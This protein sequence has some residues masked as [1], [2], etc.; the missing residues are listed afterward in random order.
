MASVSSART[1]VRA[2]LVNPHSPSGTW[3]PFT[4]LAQ[5]PHPL[6]YE[7]VFLPTVFFIGFLEATPLTQPLLLL[8]PAAVYFLLVSFLSHSCQFLM[9]SVNRS[10]LS[11]GSDA[12]LWQNYYH[13]MWLSLF[14]HSLVQWLNCFCDEG[15]FKYKILKSK[16]LLIQLIK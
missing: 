11:Q 14:W 15:Y 7:W 1:S 8:Y 4:A 13:S 12:L 10:D 5:R 16:Y 3:K 9:S 2:V 6:F